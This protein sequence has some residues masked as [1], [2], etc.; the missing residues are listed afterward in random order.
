[1]ALSAGLRYRFGPT[2]VF[3]GF[4][5]GRLLGRER[6]IDDRR[7]ERSR[8]QLGPVFGVYGELGDFDLQLGVG[9]GPL[10]ELGNSLGNRTE[11]EL[12]A[13]LAPSATLLRSLS[14]RWS[15]G[16]TTSYLVVTREVDA[17]LL[18]AALVCRL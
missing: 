18:Q 2:P 14:P 16:V 4:E 5:L 12:R 10:L 3:L 9:A 17:F 7:Q 13:F 15:L 8:L 6:I 1:M 11:A